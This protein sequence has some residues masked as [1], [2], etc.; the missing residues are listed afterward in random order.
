MQNSIK[1]SEFKKTLIELSAIG[2][3][4]VGIS[5]SYNTDV[6]KSKLNLEQNVQEINIASPDATVV[7]TPIN[8]AI[9]DINYLKMQK[10]LSYITQ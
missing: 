3:I 9:L 2:A 6:L 10:D 5:L 1:M 8:Y 7:D 4:I